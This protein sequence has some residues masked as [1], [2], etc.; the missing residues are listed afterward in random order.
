MY[1][2]PQNCVSGRVEVENFPMI[3]KILLSTP[4]SSVR[5]WGLRMWSPCDKNFINAL[6][7]LLRPPNDSIMSA[8]SVGPY[9]QMRAWHL[10]SDSD[11][12]PRAPRDQHPKEMGLRCSCVQPDYFL[13]NSYLICQW[14]R[15]INAISGIAS[16]M[17]WATCS[18]PGIHQLYM[19]P[20]T[21]YPI[22]ARSVCGHMISQLP[23]CYDHSEWF[24]LRWLISKEHLERFLSIGLRRS[25]PV[26]AILIQRALLPCTYIWHDNRKFPLST[27][28]L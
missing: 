25:D 22:T 13:I 5:V 9:F 10:I 26:N 14:S 24:M 18:M 21:C 4:V 23:G 19:S 1:S 17:G 12:A 11:R 7:S 27:S 2:L 16:P 6:T 3:P 28:K 8:W 15:G 20:T